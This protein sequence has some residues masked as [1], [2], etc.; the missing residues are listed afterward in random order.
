MTISSKWSSWKSQPE[1]YIKVAA[2]MLKYREAKIISK[3]LQY[4][5]DPYLYLCQWSSNQIPWNQHNYLSVRLSL[6]QIQLLY[7]QFLYQ[8]QI[9]AYRLQLSNFQSNQFHKLLSSSTVSV[10]MKSKIIVL[11]EGLLRKH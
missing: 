1:V 3:N 10:I 9:Q 7:H 4:N 5:L 2:K 11:N 6:P 8:W